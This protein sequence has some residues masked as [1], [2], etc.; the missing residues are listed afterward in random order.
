[1]H[2][3]PIQGQASQIHQSVDLQRTKA[4]DSFSPVICR[5]GTRY[6]DMCV[7]TISAGSFTDTFLNNMIMG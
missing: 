5:D 1:M 4:N 7:Q 3:G 2:R 6:P